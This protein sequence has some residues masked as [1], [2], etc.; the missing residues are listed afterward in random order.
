MCLCALNLSSL[1][2]DMHHFLKPFSAFRLI[3]GGIL[4][5]ALV[6]TGSLAGVYVRHDEL[7][8][9]H[10]TNLKGKKGYRLILKTPQTVR[11]GSFPREEIPSPASFK[12]NRKLF[13]LFLLAIVRAESSF[14]PY[15]VSP[16]GAKGL[17]QLM[18]AVCRQYGVK[19]PFDIRQNLRAGSAYFEDMLARFQDT[20]LALAAY[21]A[22]PE[23]VKKYGGVPPFD[24]T[25][26][27]IRRVIYFYNAYC[28]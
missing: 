18:P 14:N 8:N 16:K 7:G 3:C 27:Y 20:T 5:S 26:Q 1:E 24:E 23:Q 17:M 19:D 6:A 13:S 25:R 22:G 28:Q 15:A 2:G 12:K 11:E 10:L 9:V 4:L 21:N